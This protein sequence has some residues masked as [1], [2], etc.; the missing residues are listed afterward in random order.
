MAASPS[1]AD[2]VALDTTSTTIEDIA[3]QIASVVL[4]TVST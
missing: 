1:L 3:E 2:K 4:E